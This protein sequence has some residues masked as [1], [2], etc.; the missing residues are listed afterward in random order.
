MNNQKILENL[1]VYNP[2]NNKIRLGHLGDGG[3]IMI[4]GY[5]YDYFISCGIGGN[6]MFER[7]FIKMHPGI[8]GM[9]FDGTINDGKIVPQELKFIKKNIGPNNNENVTNLKEYVN[10][11][12]NIFIKMDIE[13]SEW[14]WIK[15][16][17]DLFMNVKQLVFEAHDIFTSNNVLECFEIINKTHYLVHLHENNNGVMRNIN[18]MLYPDLIELTF[19]RKDCKIDGLNMVDLPIKYLDYPNVPSKPEHD[20]NKWP[21]N[22]KNT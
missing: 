21:F 15:S 6:V 7:D 4:D 16:F 13:G 17:S 8:N 10:D 1:V 19:I 22:S 2:V 3:Y 11:Y 18:N 9:A 5:D 12:K 20:M 14:G